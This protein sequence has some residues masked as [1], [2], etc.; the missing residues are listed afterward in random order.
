MR[1][2]RACRP[3]RWRRS[4]TWSAG[5]SDAVPDYEAVKAGTADAAA[6]PLDAP[7]LVLW[8]AAFGAQPG[9][10][11]ALRILGPGGREVIAHEAR[12]DR[13]QA[14]LFRATG[15][16]LRARRWRGGTYRGI[17]RMLRDG[18][19]IDRIEIEIPVG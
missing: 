16:P 9:D 4:W 10:V 12:L 1:R 19:E 3:A 18:A 11:I 13:A 14:Q 5:F 2:S 6:L 8:G 7:A 17:V 15:R